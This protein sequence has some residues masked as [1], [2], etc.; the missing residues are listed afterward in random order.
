MRNVLLSIAFLLLSG[1]FTFGQTIATDYT[2]ND[3]SGTSHH[4]FAELDAGKVVVIAFVMPCSSCISPSLSAYNIVQSYAS[5]NPGRVV[6][7]L[8]DDVGTTSCSTLSTWANTNGLSGVP[9]FSNAAVHESSYGTGGMPKIVVLGG[10]NHSVYYS[11][12]GTLT[13]STFQTAINSAL[14]AAGIDEK[15]NSNFQLTVFPNPASIN[16]SVNYTLDQ[17]SDVTM[18]IYNM[19]GEKVKTVVAE[20]EILGKHH[21]DINVESLNSGCYFVKLNTDTSSEVLKFTIEK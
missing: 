10:T 15:T 21:I 17:N 19:L 13:T 12:N 11:K 18:D 14:N 2:V 20:K 6:F 4:L 1:T 5:S 7:Y 8:S 3:C 9:I 16:V